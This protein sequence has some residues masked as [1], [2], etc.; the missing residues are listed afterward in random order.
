MPDLDRRLRQVAQLRKLWRAFRDP[1]ERREDAR[2]A[3]AI[4]DRPPPFPRIQ[5]PLAAYGRLAV[6]AA[7][8]YWWCRGEYAA[9]VEL[10]ARLDPMQLEDEPLLR[11]YFDA[12]KDHLAGA[13]CQDAAGSAPHAA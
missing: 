6:R 1:Q 2:L 3:H 11:V 10:A 5:E 4:L 9:I 8:R 7:I 12:A 13:E